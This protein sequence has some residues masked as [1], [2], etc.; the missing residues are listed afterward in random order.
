M[1]RAEA[2]PARDPAA[3]PL[4]RARIR[5]RSALGARVW[6]GAPTACS[7][8]QPPPNVL[9]VLADTLRADKLGS[10][11]NSLGLTPYID[12][13]AD[14][15]VVFENATAHAP[16][17]LPSTASLLTSLY[18]QQH[19]AG[20]RIPSFTGLHPSVETLPERFGEAGYATHAIVN[21][22][23]LGESF[24]VTR[25]F[26]SLDIRSYSNNIEV[27][28]ADETTS[29]ALAWLDALETRAQK[30]FFLLVHYF[31]VHAVYAPPQPFRGQFAAPADRESD[32]F[33]FGTR[34][35][36][37]A[38]RQ[39][40]LA[41]DPQIIARAE[42]L[43]DGEVAYMDSQIGRLLD[44]L[45]ARGH[46][47][48]TITVFTTDH[49]EE[50][51]DHGG[52]EHGHTLYRELTDVPLLFCVPPELGGGAA[53]RRPHPV[54]H[55]D[56]A[57]T[58]CELTGLEPAAAYMG[59]SLVPLLTADA[60]SGERFAER[61]L[62]A[63][64]DFWDAPLSSARV[65]EFKVIVPAGPERDGAAAPAEL[66]RW[67]S[68]PREVEDLANREPEVVE[69]LEEVIEELEAAARRF[70]GVDKA[71]KVELGEAVRDHLESLGYGGG[72]GNEGDGE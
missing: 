13:L 3:E 38:L 27:R 46:G 49:G 4:T 10:Y 45:D 31:D 23:F 70:D 51:L 18:P 26:E 66:Y 69:E 55:I 34:Q 20:G 15:S 57:P 50:F 22:A 29:A 54:G 60:E 37:I 2:L 8:P 28:S 44:G 9:L 43:Y 67:Q 35:H 1:E 39:G 62:F 53:G 24:G 52:F 17:T 21:V 32:D 25:G 41:L 7:P 19:G 30:P 6:S 59:E 12:R 11:G 56:V 58:L 48:N 5:C 68:D 36:M 47:E 14:E 61:V 16:W 65:G 72:V 71:N 42:K 63:H 40:L 33:V 64:G